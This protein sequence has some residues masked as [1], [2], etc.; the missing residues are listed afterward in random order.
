MA[1]ISIAILRIVC[2][3]NKGE[4][5]IYTINKTKIPKNHDHFFD[6]IFE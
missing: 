4:T 3:H 2:D 1:Q 5:N 6:A